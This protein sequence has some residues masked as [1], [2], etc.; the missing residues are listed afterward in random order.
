MGLIGGSH[1]SSR[2]PESAPCV[3]KP[4]QVGL[5]FGTKLN[6]SAFSCQAHVRK[7]LFQESFARRT[8]DPKGYLL[9][10]E[11][12][13]NENPIGIWQRRDGSYGNSNFA[14]ENIG[15]KVNFVHL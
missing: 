15:G 2:R 8:Q 10:L 11:E 14:V 4:N 3:P 9:C 5:V 6:Q 7:A 13:P 12:T 1:N